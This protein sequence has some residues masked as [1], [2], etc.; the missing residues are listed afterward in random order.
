MKD[1]QL[2]F[3]QT[4]SS[5]SDEKREK[6]SLNEIETKRI[7]DLKNEGIRYDSIMASWWAFKL[8]SIMQNRNGEN[9]KKLQNK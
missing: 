6:F 4:L 7:Q 9:N 5:L 1:F 2:Y 8:Q 3:I